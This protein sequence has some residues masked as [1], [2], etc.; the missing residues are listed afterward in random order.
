MGQLEVGREMCLRI[1]HTT[2]L[3]INLNF[4]AVSLLMRILG[5]LA[6]GGTLESVTVT[7]H[8][9][10]GCCEEVRQHTRY[11]ESRVAYAFATASLAAVRTFEGDPT[12][13]RELLLE[14]VRESWMSDNR[15][16]LSYALTVQTLTYL[17]QDDLEQGLN[18][19]A[20]LQG[21]DATVAFCRTLLTPQLER[22]QTLALELGV[23]APQ[24]SAWEVRASRLNLQ[25]VVQGIL[26][27]TSRG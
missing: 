6:A 12:G 18:L 15:A 4:Y 19:G 26:E 5:T 17:A 24:L 16:C 9:L 27:S 23:S 1:G 8:T 11:V 10:R 20:F 25:E 7:M 2:Q 13:A 3:L 22:A 21:H 14:A